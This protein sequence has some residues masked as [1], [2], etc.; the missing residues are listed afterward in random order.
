MAPPAL[1]APLA[2]PVAAAILP[3]NRKRPTCGLHS[4]HKRPACGPLRSLP[5]ER[6]TTRALLL[7]LVVC[8]F[9]AASLGGDGADPLARLRSL[10]K[11]NDAA[12]IEAECRALLKSPLAP[13][14]AVAV[15]TALVRAVT[16]DARI[17]ALKALPKDFPEKEGLELCIFGIADSAAYR[18]LDLYKLMAERYGD[19]V[20]VEVVCK[21]ARPL[22]NP[23]RDWLVGAEAVANEALKR[24]PGDSRLL[25]ILAEVCLRT[26]RQKESVELLR[27]AI[28]NAK[29]PEVKKEMH[30]RLA[31]N[32]AMQGHDEAARQA[33]REIVREWP[34]SDWAKQTLDALALAYLR[35]E[36]PE[37]GAK[38][39][40]WYVETW[41]K[42]KWVEHCHASTPG[43]Y[44]LD[45]Q[46]DRAAEETR[47]SLPL[48]S[49][50]LRGLTE[51]DL[52]AMPSVQGQVLDAKGRPVAGATV[53]LARQSRV[54][55]STD[56]L[57][58]QQKLV[59]TRRAG[60]GHLNLIYWTEPGGKPLEIKPFGLGYHIKGPGFEDY[61]F[62]T[63]EPVKFREGQIAF[64]GRT[65][66]IRLAGKKPTLL[67]LDGKRLEWAGKALESRNAAPAAK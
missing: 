28:A 35:A 33:R 21:A 14:Q 66:L 25:D 49:E 55:I 27:Q 67:L 45:G 3:C 59:M 34:D 2:S 5:P 6:R 64:E 43:L 24:F 7:G 4:S 42:G 51:R 1:P 26:R 53:T 29:T 32:L 46:Y 50:R 18:S 44:A 47:R 57:L 56:P 39:Y 58:N 41:P 12:A 65:G 9:A 15:H 8:V 63:A 61:L 16:G 62:L 22:L 38:V 48:L 40:A 20:T 54:E 52:K 13:E 37:R 10:Q 11:I 36:G 30:E 19:K 60:D 23:R 31:R 17:E